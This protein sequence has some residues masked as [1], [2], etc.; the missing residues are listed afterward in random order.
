M[1]ISTMLLNRICRQKN[2]KIWKSFILSDITDRHGAQQSM[3]CFI[4]EWPPSPSMCHCKRLP[5][6][7]HAALMWHCNRLPA[8]LHVGLDA[9]EWLAVS[10]I[11]WVVESI[12][13]SLWHS[14][15]TH[16]HH[17]ISRA[18]QDSLG[19]HVGTAHSES[20]RFPSFASLKVFIGESS[21]KSSRNACAIKPWLAR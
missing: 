19:L 21:R 1:L 4:T 3:S 6:T 7:L 2:M 11:A 17:S 13:I 20:P 8:T 14:C 10:K 18:I 16:V 5:A 15:P 12:N 9:A